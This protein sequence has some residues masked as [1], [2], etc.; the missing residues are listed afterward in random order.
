M[1]SKA[2]RRFMNRAAHFDA[3]IEML[4]VIKRASERGALSVKSGVLFD[5]LHPQLHPRLASRQK[6]P[7]SRG[8]VVAH[9]R[10]TLYASYIKD[11]YEDAMA[12]FSDVLNAAARHGLDP[13]RLVGE[14]NLNF[15]A[16]DLLQSGSWNSVVR[17]VSDSIFRS[18]EN[19]RK[20]RKLLEKI[21]S[22]LN[23]GVDKTKIDAAM[24][25]FEMR[26]LLVHS[27]GIIDHAFCAAY[28]GFR[29]TP[30]RR[31]ALNIQRKRRA[32]QAVETL[33]KEYDD[34]IV[35]AGVIAKSDCD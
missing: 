2:Y 5:D 3:D 22:K 12:Y 16:N 32:R 9:L 11:L 8:L 20:T 26:H 29:E 28:P 10:N 17:M 34:R 13:S 35:A 33:I 31:L 30:G 27:D 7:Q 19:E 24:P 25:Y 21:D 14:Q 6:G 1:Q 18:L 15:S 4:D 23:L